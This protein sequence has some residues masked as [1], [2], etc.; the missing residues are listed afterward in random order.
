MNAISEIPT[1]NRNAQNIT[2]VVKTGGKVTGYQLSNGTVLNKANAV[3]LAKQGGI[4]DI[5]ISSRSGNEYL[6]SLPDGTENNN[7]G[8]LPV[9]PTE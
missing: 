7:L 5:G 6:K 9:V 1:P 2:G 3:N 4:A 8:S